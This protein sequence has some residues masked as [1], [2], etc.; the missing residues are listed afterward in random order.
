MSFAL[1]L[2]VFPLSYP[3]CEQETTENS[4][5]GDLLRGSLDVSSCQ[6]GKQPLWFLFD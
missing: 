5:L 1:C 3:L 2:R 6:I 4:P